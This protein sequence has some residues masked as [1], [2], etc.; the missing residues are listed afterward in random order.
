MTTI[1]V[2]LTRP[3]DPPRQPYTAPGP[4]GLPAKDV[5]HLKVGDEWTVRFVYQRN[6]WRLRVLEVNDGTL[7]AE[8][9]EGGPE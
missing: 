8:V 4:F 6:P 9:L 2:H 5:A 7:V 3:D 1:T